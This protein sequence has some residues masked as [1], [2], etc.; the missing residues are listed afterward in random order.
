MHDVMNTQSKK[1]DFTC[2]LT[3][4]TTKNKTKYFDCSGIM[5]M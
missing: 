1:Y 4:T 3:I 2:K 5:D